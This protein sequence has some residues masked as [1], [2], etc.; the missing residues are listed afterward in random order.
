MEFFQALIS[1]ILI[2]ILIFLRLKIKFCLYFNFYFNFTEFCGLKQIRIPAWWGR[3]GQ[4]QRRFWL[5]KDSKDSISAIVSR[6]SRATKSYLPR[7]KYEKW[8]SQVFNDDDGPNLGGDQEPFSGH[9][10][11][12]PNVKKASN[13]VLSYHKNYEFFCSRFSTIT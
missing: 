1:V 8:K 9:P 2:K 5:K 3:C 13:S 4:W 6:D 10:R 7:P 12:Q 11:T